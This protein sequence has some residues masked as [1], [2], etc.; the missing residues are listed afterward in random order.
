MHL[1]GFHLIDLA[2]GGRVGKVSC[3]AAE[4]AVVARIG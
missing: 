4:Y 1:T 2:A 3:N